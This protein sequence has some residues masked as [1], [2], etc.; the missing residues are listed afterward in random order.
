MNRNVSDKELQPKKMQN[1]KYLLVG[2]DSWRAVKVISRAGKR[3]GKYK[4]WF[5]VEYPGGG[6]GG[7]GDRLPKLENRT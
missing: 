4:D 1:V 5:N 3:T 2:D 7:G 6:G